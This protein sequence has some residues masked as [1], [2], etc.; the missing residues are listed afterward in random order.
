MLQTEI[1]CE[2]FF[3]PPCGMPEKPINA[4]YLLKK[5]KKKENVGLFKKYTYI[6]SIGLCAQVTGVQMWL[7]PLHFHCI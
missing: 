5:K 4:Q 7:S 2:H 1:K 3:S 6:L